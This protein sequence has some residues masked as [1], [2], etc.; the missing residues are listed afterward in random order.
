MTLLFVDD[1]VFIDP[2]KETAE[3]KLI[4]QTNTLK[5]QRI[6][7]SA[8]RKDSFSHFVN[9]KLLWKKYFKYIGFMIDANYDND[10]NVKRKIAVEQ[11]HWRATSGV[12]CN[13][14]IF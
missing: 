7:G 6:D 10:E 5:A 2:I 1:I 4:L 13:K 9:H 8:R 3:V 14:Q 11:L 12:F